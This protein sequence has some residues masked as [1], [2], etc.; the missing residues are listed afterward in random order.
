MAKGVSRYNRL[1]RDIGAEGVAAG[2]VAIQHSQGCDTATAAATIQ[3]CRCATRRGTPV[4]RPTTRCDTASVGPRHG[5]VRSR[6]GR[7]VR[8]AR[9]LGAPWS[10]GCAPM[11]PTLF[12]TQCTFSVT[13]W[14]T[15]HEHC[16]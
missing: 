8:Y 5:V 2:C 15:V 11:H 16:S 3:L 7:S 9:S 14:T 1:Y 10:V 12:W 6:L 4:T 13:V